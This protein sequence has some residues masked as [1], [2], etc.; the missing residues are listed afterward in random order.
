[1]RSTSTQP[2]AVPIVDV[3]LEAARPPPRRR[4]LAVALI[5]AGAFHVAAF[6]IALRSSDSLESWAADL[7][8]R[9]HGELARETVV[10][11]APPPPPP[12]PPPARPPPPPPER[13]P[14]APRVAA[15]PPPPAQAGQ[16]IA[17]APGPAEPLDL[18]GDTFVT[19]TA[20]A[21]AGGVTSSSGTNPLPVESRVVDPTSPPG[22]SVD[23]SR[24]AG[25]A[26]VD[27]SDCGWPPNAQSS[28]LDRAV[29]VIRVDVRPDGT[30]ASARIVRDPYPGLGFG[31][32]AV[33]CV[34]RKRVTPAQD[35]SGRP[36][37]S[38][39]LVNVRFTR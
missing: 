18:T 36:I 13:A 11:V 2:P 32:L 7:A 1:V 16:V 3:V 5:A 39:P 19:G 35:A 4:H 25:L 12:P 8:V 15:R 34:L 17:R 29:A 20:N 23:L 14:T 22:P 21:Y 33:S 9:I 28:D 38:S 27:W 30:A 24:P 26:D 37:A 31:E 6:A 10:E